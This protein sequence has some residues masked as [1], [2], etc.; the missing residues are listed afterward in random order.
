MKLPGNMMFNDN[1]ADI[2]HDMTIHAVRTICKNKRGK[3]IE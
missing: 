1:Y 2:I 3:T